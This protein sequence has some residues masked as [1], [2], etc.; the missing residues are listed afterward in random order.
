MWLPFGQ[1]IDA[2]AGL[3][4]VTVLALYCQYWRVVNKQGSVFLEQGSVFLGR[5]LAPALCFFPAHDS[6]SFI[7]F[8]GIWHWKMVTGV[9]EG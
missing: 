4:G 6:S 9:F 8:M 7:S 2:D 1:F 3:Y 5:L